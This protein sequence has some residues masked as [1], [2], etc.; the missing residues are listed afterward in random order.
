MIVSDTLY[1]DTPHPM[2]MH[3]IMFIVK[4][5]FHTCAKT[6]YESKT[7]KFVHHHELKSLALL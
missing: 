5:L 1:T 4:H 3:V 7:G 2:N 6:I